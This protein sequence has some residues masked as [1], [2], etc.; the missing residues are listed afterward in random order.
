MRAARF[1]R[2]AGGN[3]DSRPV[4]LQ[5][6]CAELKCPSGVRQCPRMAVRDASR[7]AWLIKVNDALQAP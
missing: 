7:R 6:R 5:A 4:L 3:F 2:A 1:E